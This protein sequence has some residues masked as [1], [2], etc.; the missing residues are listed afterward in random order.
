[1]PLRP[2]LPTFAVYLRLG[3]ADVANNQG[4]QAE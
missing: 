1:M 4:A 3:K 2:S